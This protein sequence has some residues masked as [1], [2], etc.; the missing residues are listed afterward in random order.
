[1]LVYLGPS[2]VEVDEA[3]AFDLVLNRGDVEVHHP[4]IIHGSNA[5]TSPKRRCG[6]TIRYIPTSTRITGDE[7]PF[8]SALLLRGDPGVNLYQPMPVYRRGDDFPFE[9]R[10]AWSESPAPAVRVRAAD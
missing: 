4:N 1:M 9:G 2:A 3:D 5:N 10:E 7:Q 6:L 8:A